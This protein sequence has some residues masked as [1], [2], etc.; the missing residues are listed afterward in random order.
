MLGAGA[1]LEA[2]TASHTSSLRS[3]DER[4]NHGRQS[5]PTGTLRPARSSV[6]IAA[7][8]GGIAT[9]QQPCGLAMSPRARTRRAL[10]SQAAAQCA[11]N[12][13]AAG[14]GGTAA[15][16]T[17]GQQRAE[18]GLRCEAAAGPRSVVLRRALQ[19][20]Y[21]E[22]Q[23]CFDAS[24]AVHGSW[25]DAPV[26]ACKRR[27]CARTSTPR[28]RAGRRDPAGV[29]RA[30]V[31]RHPKVC[32]VARAREG[33]HDAAARITRMVPGVYGGV[34]G[35]E[36]L[37]RAAAGERHGSELVLRRLGGQLLLVQ[38]PNRHLVEVHGDRHL[39]DDAVRHLGS[40]LGNIFK[41]LLHACFA[42][43]PMDAR[44]RA[45]GVCSDWSAAVVAQRELWTRRSSS[46][47]R[48]S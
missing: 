16:T 17:P 43:L 6:P 37:E 2:R 8:Q 34:Y 7:Q 4:A 12:G 40:L 48:R 30:H 9:Q 15:H 39:P 38:H 35:V 26:G 28:S 36:C 47:A 32:V 14:T 44:L 21:N 1:R 25:R 42:L 13:A 23:L 33:A 46:A 45:A 22:G 27:A 29:R 19:D 18:T 41:S 5:W 20:L 10:S 11:G 24:Q 31:W 3:S